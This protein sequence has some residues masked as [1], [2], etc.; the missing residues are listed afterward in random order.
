MAPAL[1]NTAND[2][3]EHTPDTMDNSSFPPPFTDSQPWKDDA[4]IEND[5]SEAELRRLYDD[6]EIDRFL[7][8]FADVRLKELSF[9][10][11]ITH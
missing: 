5:L 8:F 6:E 7:A 11:I 4:V 2:I 10:A 1:D 3:V 9:F